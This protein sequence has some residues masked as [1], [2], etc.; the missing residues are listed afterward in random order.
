MA[1]LFLQRTTPESDRNLQG[2]KRLRNP[3]SFQFLKNTPQQLPKLRS[4]WLIDT[5]EPPEPPSSI[6]CRHCRGRAAT[7]NIKCHRE[8]IRYIHSTSIYLGMRFI[9]SISCYRPTKCRVGGFWWLPCVAFVLM[10]II[11]PTLHEELWQRWYCS[12]KVVPCSCQAQK[13]LYNQ[14]V[15]GRRCIGCRDV[16]AS[17]RS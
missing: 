16:A 13:K 8:K 17:D 4:I 11:D 5:A 3:S 12:S 10:L 2:R 9:V 6:G 15:S 7:R 1:G 14:D